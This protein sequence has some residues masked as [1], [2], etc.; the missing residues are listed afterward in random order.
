VRVYRSCPHINGMCHCTDAEAG[1]C[2]AA[3]IEAYLDELRISVAGD[4]CPFTLKALRDEIRTI[5]RSF[6]TKN[7]LLAWYLHVNGGEFE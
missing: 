5:G 4:H 6:K 7:E 3:L 2:L 1:P